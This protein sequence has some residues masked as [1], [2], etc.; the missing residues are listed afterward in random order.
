MRKAAVKH[1]MNS[2]NTAVDLQPAWEGD[3]ARSGPAAANISAAWLSRAAC[4][5]SPENALG[6]SAVGGHLMS[7]KSEPFTG[8][9]GFSSTCRRT[10]ESKISRLT[11]TH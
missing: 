2:A 8:K 4:L 3:A 5:Y 6:S 7:S 11:M 9:L 1:Q 10:G